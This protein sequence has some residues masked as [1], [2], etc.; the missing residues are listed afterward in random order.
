MQRL[1]VSGAVRPIYGSLG[2]KR[3]KNLYCVTVHRMKR[4][5]HRNGMQKAVLLRYTNQ[6]FS[7]PKTIPLIA[8]VQS[9]NEC[10]EN[11]GN[12]I[13]TFR[14]QNKI[15]AVEKQGKIW[16]LCFTLWRRNYF[17]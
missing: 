16:E 17:F 15:Q 1:E 2:V 11:L 14:R 5:V 6:C 13:N 3:L 7:I 10:S 4:E 9:S 8:F 12:N